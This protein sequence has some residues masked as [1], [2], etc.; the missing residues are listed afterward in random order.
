MTIFVSFSFTW[1]PAYAGM[2]IFVSFSFTWIP[3]YAGMTILLTLFFVLASGPC[4]PEGVRRNDDIIHSFF[5]LDSSPYAQRGYAGMT[6]FVS[7]SFTRHS[8][9]GRNPEFALLL[10]Y[11]DHS[12]TKTLTTGK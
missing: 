2:T 11:T 6:T 5:A 10:L 4:T 7:F 9:V 3:A 12:S 8:G 1:I